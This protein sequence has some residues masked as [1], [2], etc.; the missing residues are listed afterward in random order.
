MRGALRR[1][2]GDD[3]RDGERV[4]VYEEDGRGEREGDGG[5][6]VRTVRRSCRD[7]GRGY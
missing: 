4:E 2:E 1:G 7:R 5:E 3:E 6:R